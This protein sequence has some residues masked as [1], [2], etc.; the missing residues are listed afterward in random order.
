VRRIRIAVVVIGTFVG[1]FGV[2]SHVI[3]QVIP[4]ALGHRAAVV[5]DVQPGQTVVQRVTLP[6]RANLVGVSFSSSDPDAAGVEIGVRY[7]DPGAW[8]EWLDVHIEADENPDAAEM[9]DASAR[10]ATLPQWVDLAKQIQIRI[11]LEP[12]ATPLQ[13]V[14]LESYN[15]NGDAIEQPGIVR[16]AHT[17]GRVLTATPAATPAEAWTTMPKIITRAEWGANESWRSSG[18][19][20]ADALVMAH[21]HHTVNSNSYSADESAALVR[22]IYR[23]HTQ[24]RGYSDIGYNLLVDRYGQIFEGRKGSIYEP[25]IGG[26]AAGFNGGSTGIALIGTFTSASP[27]SAMIGALRR[28]LAW[29]LDY[30]HVPPTGK[31]LRISGGSTK[32]AEGKRVWLN[33]MSGHR[34]TSS[35][36][37]PGSTV[38]SLLPSIR[39][40]VNDYGHPK[41]YLPS[42][43]PSN[44][45]FPGLNPTGPVEAYSTF[46]RTVSWRFR[47]MNGAG[48]VVFSRS[49]S[50]RSM[51]A[52]WNGH[53]P[54]GLLVPSGSYPWSLTAGNSSGNARAAAGT[55]GIDADFTP[56]FYDDD[57]SSHEEN[58]VT[59]AERGTTVGCATQRFCTMQ[60]LTRA[61][62]ATFLARELE[63]PTVGTDYFTDDDGSIH[64]SNINRIAKE[65]ITAGCGP[66]T[67]CPNSLITRAQMAVFLTNALHLPPATLDYFD[68]DDG[69]PYEDSINRMAAAGITSGCGERRFCPG[70]SVIRAHMATFLVRAF[71]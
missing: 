48:D 23:Y 28:L 33:R 1:T 6:W 68:D 66:T 15:T 24:T 37:C 56:P 3:A 60:P 20:T 69:S 47:I 61:Q 36:S 40:W 70:S 49:G 67:F 50:G 59:L 44:V 5:S 22:G 29:K 39:S 43:E 21:V 25:V 16:L 65:E 11:E 62:M 30:H 63:L 54:D 9:R 41:I 64:E 12:D 7:R 71:P 27:P 55:L 13:D 10:N 26:H 35:T 52:S 8:S 53:G 4:E 46:S 58:I 57:G 45:R 17:I 38:Y 19:G 31:V 18:P 32:Y 51:S 42:V 2:Q 34:D 14:R